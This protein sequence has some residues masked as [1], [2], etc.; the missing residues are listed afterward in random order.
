MLGHVSDVLDIHGS[1][2]H[3]FRMTQILVA[4]RSPYHRNCGASIAILDYQVGRAVAL[5]WV[6]YGRFHRGGGVFA[7]NSRARVCAGDSDPQDFSK[8]AEKLYSGVFWGV[9][10]KKNDPRFDFLIDGWAVRLI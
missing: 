9:E 10:S 4:W 8:S 1:H 7:T 6:I 5:K 2:G 3:P